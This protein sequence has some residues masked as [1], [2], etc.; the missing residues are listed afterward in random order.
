MSGC[1]T[2]C[3]CQAPVC[4]AWLHAHAC[5]TVTKLI[6]SMFQQTG[7]Y[8]QVQGD[9][10]GLGE[11]QLRPEALGQLLLHGAQV[12]SCPPGSPSSLAAS[13][14]PSVHWVEP[15]YPAYPLVECLTQEFSIRWVFLLFQLQEQEGRSQ[16]ENLAFLT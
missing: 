11:R 16:R 3:C 5:A 6:F 8:P 1:A 13:N 15:P 14:A 2:L 10:P 4:V 12:S 9:P 7:L